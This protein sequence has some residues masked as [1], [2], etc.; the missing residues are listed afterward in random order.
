MRRQRPTY[1]VGPDGIALIQL[2]ASVKTGEAVL[3]FHFQEHQ[4]EMR[5]WLKPGARD[6]ILVGLAEGTVGYNTLSG[7]MEPLGEDAPDDQ[8]YSEGRVAFYAKGSIKG[9]W[10]ATMA[11]D[12]GKDWDG[13][14]G[15]L[16]QE[17]DPDQYFTLYGD[18]SR[19][20]YDASSSRKLY[21][22]IE[23]HQFYALFGDYNTGLTI[24]ELAKYTRAFNGIKSELKTGHLGLNLFANQTGHGYM[25]D[26]IRGD[27]T[28][29]MY[30]LTRRDLVINSEEITIEVRDRFRSELILSSRKL[31]R[32][33]DYNIDYDDGSLYFKEPIPS[34]DVDLN[35]IFIVANYE[36]RSQD[37]DHN[38][39]GGR[40]SVT[41]LDGKLELGTTFIHQE[42]NAGKGELMGVDGR[43]H[44]GPQTELKGEYVVT[45]TDMTGRH[46]AY[47]AEIKNTAGR[48]GA[49]AY[50]RR[51]EVG[52][53]LGQ[54]NRSESG[55]NKVGVDLDWKM[56]SRL[57][58]KGQTWRQDNL[59][60]G[61]R[62]D[63]VE[64]KLQWRDSLF[65]LHA[66]G[67]YVN[68]KF[69]TLND[70]KS[71]QLLGG[72]EISTRNK[73]L[74]FLADHE[75]SVSG[76]NANVDYPTRTTLGADY[77][78]VRNLNLL[79]RYEI[80]N[81]ASGDTRGARV[82]FETKPWSGSKVS[83]SYERRFTE[84]GSRAFANLGLRQLWKVSK[85]WTLDFGL[86][87][88][89]ATEGFDTPRYN[90]NVPPASGAL[91]GFTAVSTAVG[92]RAERWQWNTRFEIRNSALDDKWAVSPSV[93]V[94]PRSGLGLAGKA[95]ILGSDGADGSL[96]RNYD[97]RFGLALRP[98]REGW[99]ILDRLDWITDER[100]SPTMDL[101]GW[102]VVNHLNLTYFS[103][104]NTQ[105]ALQYGAK[106]NQDDIAGRRYSGFTDLFGGEARQNLSPTMDVGLRLSGLH[107]WKSRQVDYSAGGSFGLKVMTNIW[108][109]L[110]YNFVGFY[111]V[112]FSAAD[113]T[114]KGPF[115]RFRMKFDQETAGEILKAFMGGGQQ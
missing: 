58:L 72:G 109:S 38:N 99:V 25:R 12:T 41:T 92:Y 62:R 86:D 56:S 32:H 104:R 74:K 6:W 94:E 80:T 51:N 101:A 81:G 91:N 19:Q 10:L 106:Y 18:G 2:Q 36:T 14:T 52:F 65:S 9:E 73:R 5:T 28:S 48:L 39:F 98:D 4:Q 45:D 113:F 85:H 7:N 30:Y 105:I 111:D 108:M 61:A 112:D 40:G 66:G 23:R 16:Y 54:Q 33:L 90:E 103:G 115:L 35:P 3:H 27:G 24:N 20:D 63:N 71:T 13:D 110:G 95:R 76:N 21:V 49:R 78:I 8:W 79:T 55:T 17:I 102:R 77:E 93:L 96:R 46:D 82:G 89:E 50:L 59:A 83:S 11:F 87:H 37:G 26:E 29:G 107:S 114:A 60:N 34:K 67:R 15:A 69:T 44:F 42:E 70:H 53:G 88:S 75:Q 64:G 47:L 22:K 43:Y 57:N 97:V 84:N 1:V 31:T 100:I 68:D